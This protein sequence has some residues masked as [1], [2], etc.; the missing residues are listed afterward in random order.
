MVEQGFARVDGDVLEIT[1]LG[2]LFVRN[3]CMIFDAHLR[4][5]ESGKQ[6]FSRTV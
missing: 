6:V 2:R 1:P 5:K 4:K 3:L